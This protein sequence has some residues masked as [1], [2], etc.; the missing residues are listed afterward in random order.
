MAQRLPLAH[1]LLLAAFFILL[2]SGTAAAWNDPRTE[3][4]M[5]RVAE[6][7]R[8]YAEKLAEAN[9][10]R[11]NADGTAKFPDAALAVFPAKS[12]NQWVQPLPEA[13]RPLLPLDTPLAEREY[14]QKIDR[15]RSEYANNL[16]RIAQQA[17]GFGAVQ[18]AYELFNEAARHDPDSPAIR[19]IL[20]FVRYENLWLTPFEAEMR[21]K[22]QVWHEQFGWLPADWV[23]RYE[24]GERNYRGRWITATQEAELRRDFKNA[25]TVETEHYSVE[26]NHSLERGVQVAQSLEKF[27]AFFLQTFPAFF[28]RPDDAATLLKGLNATANRSRSRYKV[29][30]YRTRDEYVSNL[31]PKIANIAMTNGFYSMSDRVAYFYEQ[32]HAAGDETLYHEATH[33]IFYECIARQREVGAQAHFWVLEGIACYMESFSGDG[34][35]MTVGNPRHLRVRAAQYRINVDKYYLPLQQFT[36]MGMVPFQVSPDIQK[37]YSQASGLVYFF[38]HYDGGRYRDALIEHLAQQYH[39]SGPRPKSPATLEELTGVSYGELD[40]LYAKF[41]ATLN[42]GNISTS[43]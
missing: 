15:L 32:D 43:Q 24:K 27:Y 16:F 38:M 17:L 12:G 25:W 14:R 26:T 7:R 9:Q 30:Y 1:K 36:A 40:Q 23:P 35:A 29:H 31:S 18:Y 6:L 5:N 4:L 20:G 22:H 37:N 39:T 3:L 11:L 8:G 42:G 2:N 13:V 10:T 28:T 21:R 34:N 41:M 19:K 33:Q